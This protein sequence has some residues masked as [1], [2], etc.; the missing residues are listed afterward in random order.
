MI[1]LSTYRS[2]GVDIDGVLSDIAGHLVMFANQRFNCNLS[3]ADIVSEN[4]ENCSD[5]SLDQL[6][7]IFSTAAFFKTLPV[8]NSASE[9]LK[10]LRKHGLKI[11]LMTDRFWYPKIQEDTVTWLKRNRI[12][13]DSVRF[14]EKRNKAEMAHELDLKLFI[15][16]QLSN[17]NALAEVCENVF[18][19]NRR[20]NQGHSHHNVTR[21]LSVKEATAILTTTT[22]LMEPAARL[23]PFHFGP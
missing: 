17:A 9:S 11:V 7:Q 1:K 15:E 20:Y 22:R 13:F 18:L 21:V 16:D 2:I 10:Q 3:V 5:L 12:P 6:R 8:V 19:V 4:V 14:V 23:P